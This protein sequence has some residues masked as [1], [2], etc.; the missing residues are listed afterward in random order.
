[1]ALG[2]IGQKFGHCSVFAVLI[3]QCLILLRGHSITKPEKLGVIVVDFRAVEGVPSGHGC[4]VFAA[5]FFDFN[6]RVNH[7]AVF[8]SLK[9]CRGFT[10]MLLGNDF[11]FHFLVEL[12]SLGINAAKDCESGIQNVVDFSSITNFH[13]FKASFQS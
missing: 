1:M 4:F 8:P 10:I 12:L 3:A 6:V 7:G 5:D 2:E 11:I 13:R 9:L